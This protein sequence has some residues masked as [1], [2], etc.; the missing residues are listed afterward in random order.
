MMSIRTRL[1]A[2]CLIGSLTLPSGVAFAGPDEAAQHYEDASEAYGQGDYARAADLLERAYA[3]DPNLIYQYN[4]V[5][6][7]QAMGKYKEALKVV[8]I[9][10]NPM[11]E[12]GRFDDI[13]EIRAE[14][15]E[16]RAEQV[17]AREEG[18]EDTSDPKAKDQLSGLDGQDSDADSG[19]EPQVDDSGPNIL[20][21]SLVGTGAASLGAAGLFGSTILISDVADRR[22]CMEPANTSLNACYSD[23]DDPQ[24]QYDSDRDTW[25]THRTLTW[26]FLG[27]GSTALIG[28]GV[29][30]LM[31]AND[32]EADTSTATAGPEV[33]VT[34]YVGADGAGG[35]LRLDF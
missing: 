17:A 33:S 2:I 5:L 10:E 15:E 8:D 19:S 9:Y 34:P 24:S 29:L 14:L 23:F 3:E 6:A 16:A 7:L 13:Q 20:A 26:V 4:R 11:L 18:R 35:V 22:D 25:G 21:W 30:L 27:V 31:D 12:D 1:L 32:T 28:G